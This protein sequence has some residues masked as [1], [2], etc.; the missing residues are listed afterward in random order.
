MLYSVGM[1]EEEEEE[2]NIR[3]L[4]KA[5]KVG[6]RIFTAAT[7]SCLMLAVYNLLPGS[8]LWKSLTVSSLYLLR[9]PAEMQLSKAVSAL[10][11]GSQWLWLHVLKYSQHGGGLEFQA[12]QKHLQTR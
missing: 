4:I 9:T 3:S 12:F 10:M 6:G 7:K 1:E 8:S 11:S 5:V 2:D